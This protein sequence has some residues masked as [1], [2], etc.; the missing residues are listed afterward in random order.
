MQLYEDKLG[1]L[2]HTRSSTQSP[3]FP[4]IHNGLKPLNCTLNSSLHKSTH[5]KYTCSKTPHCISF[6]LQVWLHPR[7][8]KY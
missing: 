6:I 3:T 4:H 8:Q 7:S 2:A 1:M 5:H